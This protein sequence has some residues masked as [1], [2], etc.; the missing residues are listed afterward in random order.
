MPALQQRPP[1]PQQ[2]ISFAKQ[3]LLKAVAVQVGVTDNTSIKLE[4]GSLSCQRLCPEEKPPIWCSYHL[5]QQ[6]HGGTGEAIESY[7]A[8]SCHQTS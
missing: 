1:Y 7:H 4:W 3:P 8:L 2:K 6:L 5:M